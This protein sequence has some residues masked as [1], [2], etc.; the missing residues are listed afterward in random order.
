MSTISLTEQVFA[1]RKQLVKAA[2]E[3]KTLF[4][5]DLVEEDTSFVR[6]LGTILEWIT[7]YDMEN[8]QSILASIGKLK[9]KGLP[10]LELFEY[11]KE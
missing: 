5:S 7:P 4:Y 1:I 2:S 9:S 10:N 11:F 6:S 3:Q 8:K